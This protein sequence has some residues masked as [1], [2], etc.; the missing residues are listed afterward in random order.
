MPAIVLA[1]A[2]V[3]GSLLGVRLAL[4]VSHVVTRW[5]IFACVVASCVGAW[6]KG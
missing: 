2:T 5:I 1:A 3:V 4:R 6:I